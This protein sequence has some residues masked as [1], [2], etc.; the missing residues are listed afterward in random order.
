MNDITKKRLPFRGVGTALVTPFDGSGRVDLPTFSRLC[1]RQ[2]EGGA[3][4]LVVAGTTGESVTLRKSERASLL[5]AASE[6]GAGRVSI[7]AGT[8]SA[9]TREA[10]S[11]ARYAATHG[12][13]A[14][15]VVTPYYNKGTREGL[16]KHYLAIAEAVDIPIILYNV[17]SR[18][19]VN[20]PMEALGRLAEHENI[21]AIKEASGNIDRAADIITEF[22]ERL[23]LYS[24]NDGEIL[25]TLA[26]GG[27]GVISVVSN[28][29]PQE[30]VKLCTLYDGG[31]VEEARALAARLLPLIRLLFADTNPAPVKY[32]MQLLGLASAEVRLPLTVPDGVLAERIKSA[33]ITVT[34]H[35]E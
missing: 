23:W 16:V 32:A 11:N 12:A 9:D 4:A 8:G 34:G 22:S 1:E 10:V 21:V 29:L 26:L 28:L 19:G 35:I 5:F 33:L 13:D 3:A 25:P 15:L 31:R 7:V 27:V 6:A 17:P 20:I 30:T 24:G 2:I 18:T 14:L